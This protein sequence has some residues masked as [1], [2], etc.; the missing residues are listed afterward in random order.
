[1][2]KVNL[3]LLSGNAGGKL[4]DIVFFKRGS[5]QIARIRVKPSNPRTEKQQLIRHNMKAL[6]E[7]WRN[8]GQN[9][10][11]VLKKRVYDSQTGTYTYQDVQ[12]NAQSVD[13]TA[14]KQCTLYSRSG[15]PLKGYQ[16]FTSTNLKRLM[17]GENPVGKPSDAGLQC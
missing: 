5:V 11:V 1:M 4:G 7:A 14:W 3:P 9:H 16:S 10:T 13:K 8:A 15:F 2:A 6:G 17:S 12:F